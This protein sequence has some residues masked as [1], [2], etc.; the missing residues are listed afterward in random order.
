MRSTWVMALAT[1]LAIVRPGTAQPAGD[2]ARAGDAAAVAKP[3]IVTREDW[4]S[5]PDPI[6]DS[7]RH[8]PTYV[9]IH[10]A[11]VLWT[12][13]QEPEEFLRN[14][15]A[16]GKRRPEVEHPPRN[17]YWPDLAYHFLIAPDGRIFEGR[18]LEYEPES[19]TN[20][21]LAGNINVELMGDFGRQRPSREQLELLVRLTA[22][23]MQE[24]EIGMTEVRTHRDAA[25]G[26]TECPGADLYRYFEDGQFEEWVAA[27]ARGEDP[28][29]DPGAPLDGGPTEVI[30]ETRR[31]E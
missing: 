27:T 17:T 9:T 18:P 3:D 19:N 11:G 28:A 4:G 29:V 23:L 30:T 22:W 31:A 5:T 24:L 13:S 10:H 26:Q 14:M 2:D 15:Q 8:T 7:R 1:V 25:P 20:Y 6:P 21:D 16:W 12:N